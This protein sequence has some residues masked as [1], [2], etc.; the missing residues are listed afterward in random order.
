[1]PPYTSW[2]YGGQ[3]AAAPAVVTPIGL[4]ANLRA[5]AVS[6]AGLSS[7]GAEDHFDGFYGATRYSGSGNGGYSSVP[8]AAPTEG[9]GAWTLTTG[10]ASS[11]QAYAL[12]DVRGMPNAATVPWYVAWRGAFTSALDAL[13]GGG[14]GFTS[15]LSADLTV[16]YV[17]GVSTS[18]WAVQSGGA[19][20]PTASGF[21]IAG[22]TVD[23]LVH[24][25]ELWHKSGTLYA[26]VDGG[27]IST[28]PYNGGMSAFTGT[29]FYSK[30]LV[31]NGGAGVRSARF[32]WVYLAV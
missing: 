32:E 11:S 31:H 2:S 3:P 18:T 4:V 20:L 19:A 28:G 26:R 15:A 27:A 7:S 30:F 1:M 16:G 8:N 23:Q 12:A 5:T 14:A 21:A 10:G 25:W 6:V 17:G 24:T 9:M 13:A 29:V 22:T